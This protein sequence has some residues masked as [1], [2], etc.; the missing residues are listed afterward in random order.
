MIKLSIIIPYYD[1]YDMTCKLLDRLTPQLTKEV[2]VI[3]VDDGCNH[4][5]SKYDIRVI[6]KEH[7]GWLS[8]SP[9]RNLG[10][11]NAQGKYISFVDSDDMVSDDYVDKI[12]S[13]INQTDFDYCYISWTDGKKNYVIDNEPPQ[14]NKSVWNCV[15]HKETIGKHRFRENMQ[16]AEDWDFN[17]RVRHGKRENITDILYYYNAGRQDSL[18]DKYSKGEIGIDAPIKAQVVMFLRFVSKIGGV[19]TFVY[20]FIKRFHKEHDIIFLYEEADPQQLRRLKK[21]CKCKI[22]K[23]EKVECK[24]YLNVNFSKNI[25]DNVTANLYL[26]MCHTD[27]EA[28]GWQYTTH[29]KTDLTICVS[30]VVENSLKKQY[31]K[32]KTQVINNLL[33]KPKPKRTLLLVS[34]TRLSW[35]KGYWRMKEMAKALNQLKIP[36]IWLVFTN[37]RPDEDIDGFVFMKPRLNVIDYVA[38]ADYLMQLSNTEAYG[39]STKE[40]MALGV[41]I[42]VTDYPSIKEQGFVDGINGFTLD[43]ELHNLGEV[44]EKMYSKTLQP[45]EIHNECDSK[46]LPH[47]GKKTKSKYKYDENE[48]ETEITDD[49]WVAKQRIRDEEGNF[50]NAGEIAKL[51][52]SQRIRR[53]LEHNM[54]ERKLI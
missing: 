40:A 23:G 3:L 44:I 19:E 54:I 13:K 17:D 36:F 38:K 7:I 53:L 50:I 6:K 46:W 24:T 1:T 47:L 10:I 31:P 45:K 9:G 28:M 39:Y 52:S 22:Y 41:P 51:Y 27:Y 42:I 18:T 25:A 49:V 12:L 35:E 21:M 29:P 11:D 34:A 16:Y 43:M 8:A 14:F 26:D 2:E 15:Y 20:E 37:D 4:D 48:K 33:E 5:F 30:K 32:L